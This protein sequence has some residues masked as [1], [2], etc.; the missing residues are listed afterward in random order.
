MKY[1]EE[2]HG[3]NFE[4]LRHFLA[5][6]F[7][8]ELFSTAGQ[9]RTVAINA[10]ALALP[11]GMAL[12]NQDY[13][14]KYH[15]LSRF[16]SP[17]P[18]RAA[19]ITDEFGLLMLLMSI[20]G[21]LALM[22]W[23]SLYPSGRD[24]LALA[25]LPVRSRQIFGARF[26]CVA[27]LSIALVGTL[28][29]ST[30]AVPLQFAG[31]WQK[32]PSLGANLAA[33]AV[34]STLGCF[35]IFFAVVAL[36]GVLLNALPGR[37]FARISTGV[38]G[39]LTGLFF[40][41]IL[42]SWSTPDWLYA[43]ALKSSWFGWVPPVWFTGLHEWMLGD[44]DPFFTGLARSAIDGVA[45]VAALAVGGYV[46][47][48]R[49][50]RSLLIE[51]SIHGIAARVRRYS[52]VRLLARDPRKQAILQFMAATLARSRMHR[53]ILLAY[54]GGAIGI[55]INSSLIAGAAARWAG[56]WRG[57]LKFM[58]LYWPIGL[59]FVVLAG[60][61]HAF[62]IPAE[63]PANWLFRLNESHG[64]AEWMSA[65]ERFVIVCV[66]APLYAVL[67]PLAAVVL[68]WGLAFRMTVFEV[69]ISLAAFEY[70]FYSWQQLPFACSYVPGKRP[71][72]GVLAIYMVV[73][74]ALVPVLARIVAA[75]SVFV[76][77]FLIYLPVFAGA[78]LWLHK[79]RVDGWGESRLFY[80][81]NPN[82]LPDL[83]ISELGY[84][85]RSAL[86]DPACR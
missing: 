4:L 58:V 11:A 18:F 40:L 37:L 36:Y 67:F 70:L 26:A 86:P 69:F 12:F 35:F 51:N 23:N 62:S 24:Y 60:L 27:L 57:S 41:A 33:Q 30:V 49:R 53:M 82:A 9:W 42:V 68:G 74:A 34:S 52:L 3:T 44:R 79:L 15:R 47:S 17:E 25:G 59:S 66:I 13:A 81:D 1:L 78:W 7:D 63:L 32:N 56:G 54:A 73:L 61:R 14:A 31:R 85:R 43:S 16:P 6:M 10:F 39:V 28:N 77:T 83:G 55:M 22:Q 64:R 38:Q 76:E 19:A 5:R 75:M 50:Y 46:L 2:T 71:L 45:M 20:T 21:L 80:E 8:S 29:L 72:W 65:V 84:G 48:Y